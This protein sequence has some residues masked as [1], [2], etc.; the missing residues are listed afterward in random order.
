MACWRAAY[1]A[2]SIL[3]AVPEHRPEHAQLLTVER[4]ENGRVRRGL[5]RRVAR[6]R[7]QDPDAQLQ[8]QGPR[9]RRLRHD[10]G[11][12]MDRLAFP[13]A[14]R[15]E[16]G[17]MRRRAVRVGQPR[18]MAGV[19]ETSVAPAGRGARSRRLRFSDATARSAKTD[20]RSNFRWC[21]P[22]EM[23]A[24]LQPPQ[25]HQARH[26]GQRADDEEP[27]P[28]G[29]LGD[30]TRARRQIGASD[31]RRARSAA[32]I[33]SPCAAGFGTAP[34]DRRRRSPCRSRW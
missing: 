8:P 7:C 9:R 21:K 27:D 11:N 3:F 12:E 1:N 5:Q 15:L 33:A 25:Q 10:P 17:S 4:W 29:R 18:Q 2:G 6:L 28:S 13:P 32:R 24:H 30:I 16:Q 22:V 34:R 20:G 26:R 23:P 31:R 19:P 14:Q